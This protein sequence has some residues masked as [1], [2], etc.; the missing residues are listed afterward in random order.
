L[1]PLAAA[2]AHA[3][4]EDDTLNGSGVFDT[5]SSG[6]PLNLSDILATSNG[7]AEPDASVAGDI[8][9]EEADTSLVAATAGTT[10]P[11]GLVTV[12]NELLMQADTASYA[13]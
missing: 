12:M 13:F 8:P 7:Y 6:A 3:A 11:M 10:P 4:T 1:L 2:D 5:S 9:F